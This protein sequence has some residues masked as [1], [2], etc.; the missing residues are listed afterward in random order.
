MNNPQ[1]KRT[2]ES[3]PVPALTLTPQAKKTDENPDPGQPKPTLTNL[4]CQE[5][6][7]ILDKLINCLK[8]I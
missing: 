1:S 2:Y 8:K 3:Q 7:Q 4:T 6:A 5:Q